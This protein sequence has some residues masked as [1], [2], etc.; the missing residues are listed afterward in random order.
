MESNA[1]LKARFLLTGITDFE[2]HEWFYYDKVEKY[3]EDDDDY[4][5]I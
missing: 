4:E 3:E 2:R 5:F 1:Q